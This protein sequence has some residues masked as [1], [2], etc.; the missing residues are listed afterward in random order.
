MGGDNAADSICVEVVYAEPRCQTIVRLELPIG[1]TVQQAVEASGLLAKFPEISRTNRK[2][3]VY[4]KITKVGTVLRAG[5]RVEIYRPLLADPKEN[6]K[7]RAVAAA[8]M[9]NGLKR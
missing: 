8:E 1:S 5:D 9:R 4:G 3:G 2:L 6:R 7:R